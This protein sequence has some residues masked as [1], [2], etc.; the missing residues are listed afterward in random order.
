MQEE[1]TVEG[2]LPGF[3][4][5]GNRR[6]SKTFDLVDGLA[7]DILLFSGAAFERDLAV[8]VGT[9]DDLHGAV[10]L[11]GV[12]DRK[13]DGNGFADRERPVR[14]ILMPG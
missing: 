2:H 13:P 3:Q 4:I 1:I 8:Q 9:G 5:D 7:E 10:F 6:A 14:S 12:I 11:I